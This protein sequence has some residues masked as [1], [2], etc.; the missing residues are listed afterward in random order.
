MAS[1]GGTITK[2]LMMK[3]R[4]NH[5]N[6][7]H[8]SEW[9]WSKPSSTRTYSYADAKIM[10]ASLRA[11]ELQKA[12]TNTGLTWH[13]ISQEQE[14]FLGNKHTCAAPGYF[15]GLFHFITES[16]NRDILTYVPSQRR[17]PWWL[18]AQESTTMVLNAIYRW[19]KAFRNGT[20]D[21]I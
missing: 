10:A 7:G 19:L 9:L 1:A 20:C 21:T 3:S 13:D 8:H 5:S 14:M 4:G 17:H 11:Y 2:R 12:T 16:W 15:L 6:E 18:N